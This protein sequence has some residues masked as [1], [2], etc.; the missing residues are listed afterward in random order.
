M[1]TIQLRKGYRIS[2]YSC[3]IFLCKT[4]KCQSL[5]G[6]KHNKSLLLKQL[7]RDLDQSKGCLW[8]MHSGRKSLKVL[9]LEAINL[10]LCLLSVQTSF[11][12][13]TNRIICKTRPR[14]RQSFPE[15]LFSQISTSSLTDLTRI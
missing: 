10:P 14:K 12:H 5:L 6:K 11:N 7:F 15:E 2:I 4:I 9:F 13:L 8:A 3:S 1:P